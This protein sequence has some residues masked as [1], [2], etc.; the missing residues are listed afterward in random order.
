VETT[1]VYH[2]PASTA[3]G[4]FALLSVLS[5]LCNTY[6]Y[7]LLSVTVVSDD[8]IIR[9]TESIGVARI[10]SGGAL[11]LAKKVDDLFL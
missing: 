7:L 10:L 6:V 1:P 5:L 3:T 4:R 8:Y 11:F 2:S 9:Y